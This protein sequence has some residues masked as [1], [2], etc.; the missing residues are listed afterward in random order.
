MPKEN[1]RICEECNKKFLIIEQEEAFYKKK[2]LPLPTRCPDCRRKI[3]LTFK[4][5]RKLYHRDCDKCRK[6]IITTYP[7]DTPY[8]I[9]CQE[10]YWQEMQ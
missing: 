2:D 5:P 1:T 9:Y 8:K 6:D 4:N 10:C 7:P 3:R